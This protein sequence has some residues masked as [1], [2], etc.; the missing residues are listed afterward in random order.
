MLTE[1]P[2]VVIDYLLT[3][4]LSDNDLRVMHQVS[5]AWKDLIDQRPLIT[6]RRMA[7][8]QRI[9]EQKENIK[10]FTQVTP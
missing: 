5:K 8:V 10:K 9:R 3:Y 1:L 7:L 6:A 2:T 4:F